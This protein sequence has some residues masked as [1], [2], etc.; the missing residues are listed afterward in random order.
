VQTALLHVS[1]FR[2]RVDIRSC[3]S[4]DLACINTYVSEILMSACLQ[5]L[6]HPHWK[7]VDYHIVVEGLENILRE[8]AVIDA[9]VLVLL[10]LGQ[11]ILSDVH[12]DEKSLVG[13]NLVVVDG[14]WCC[15]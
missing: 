15:G 8:Q 4:Q 3:N 9:R 2:Q 7:A 13:A 11:L 12:H 6:R 1:W 5:N 14:C 10:E